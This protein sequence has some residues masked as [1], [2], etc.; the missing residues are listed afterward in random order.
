MRPGDDVSR[1][2]TP[3]GSGAGGGR[4]RR[5]SQLGGVAAKH[6]ARVAAATATA[7][8]MSSEGADAARDRN[9]LKL[10]D[11]VVSVVGGMR[12]AAHKLGQVL[13]VL[14]LGISTRATR[15]EF[16]RRLEPLFAATPP[17]ND[18]AMMRV[19]DQSL[20][21]RRADIAEL[22]GPIASASIGQ[23]YRGTLSDGRD[24]AVKIKYPNVDMMVR[25]DMKNLKMLARVLTRYVPA[26]NVNELVAEVARQ[27]TLELDF[28]AEG[29]TQTMFADRYAGHPAFRIP[30]PIAE[31]CTDR[32]LVTEFVDG[33][34]FDEACRLDRPDRDLIGEIVYR[35]YCGEMYRTGTFSGDPHPGNMIILPDRTV[36][37]LDFGL[38]ISLTPAE[39]A[40]EQE[41]FG[42]L[43]A[44]DH[45][46]T[47][48]LVR[49]AGFI[50]EPETLDAER[51]AAYAMASVGW[52]VEPGEV[53][54]T[55]GV[56]R[57]A[58]MAAVSPNGGY[59]GSMGRQTLVE[60]HGF[61]RR[62]EL[63]TCSLLGR[64]RST[65]PWSS[66]ASENLGLSGPATPLGRE[67]ARWASGDT[68]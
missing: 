46:R 37:F 44:G 32:V 45:E 54:I 57:R 6:A 12:G 10:A 51:F 53:T 59:V 26:A 62:N 29:A 13:A 65:A 61:G 55:D 27:I 56:A 47:Y 49:R 60:G 30:R 66:I 25:A 50:V 43:L 8:F 64:L 16:K 20:G 1:R 38:S 48:E 21:D 68:G 39:L 23:V 19:L 4:I 9:V 40:I 28:V 7:R 58:A 2:S 18:A 14:D 35:F 52:H 42:S 31:L 17:W 67:I 41:V 36:A 24:V 3:D 34:S 63:A 11:D 15:E 5:G 33:L 22:D